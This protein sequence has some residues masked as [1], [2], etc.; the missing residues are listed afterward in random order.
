MNSVLNP[1]AKAPLTVGQA[2]VVAYG[3]L[4]R[5][6]VQVLQYIASGVL[7]ASSFEGGLVSAGLARCFCRSL[8]A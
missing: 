6:P 8:E 2:I 7:E 4:G 5:N 3:L 1:F